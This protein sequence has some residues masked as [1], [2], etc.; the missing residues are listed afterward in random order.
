MRLFL[1]KD[2]ENKASEKS[3]GVVEAFAHAILLFA[4]FAPVFLITSVGV[5]SGQAMVV[6]L[7]APHP[8]QAQVRRLLK[9]VWVP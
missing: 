1:N 3:K 6:T 4:C 9:E 7:P 8:Y 5:A 2:W